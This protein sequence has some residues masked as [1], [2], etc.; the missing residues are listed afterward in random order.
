MEPAERGLY[1]VASLLLITEAA[2]SLSIYEVDIPRHIRRGEDTYLSCLFDLGGQQLYATKW[3]KDGKEIYRYEPSNAVQ[4]KSFP[5]NGITVDL[6]SSN[7]THVRLSAPTLRYSGGYVCEVSLDKP[8]FATEQ[9]KGNVRVV[10]FPSDGPII[11]G[12]NPRYEV[13]DRVTVN[14]TSFRS[15]PAAQLAWYI[16]NERASFTHLKLWPP[17]ID[18][19]DLQTVT[20]GL[21]FRVRP[22]HFRAGDL[23]LKC[24][25]QLEDPLGPLYWRSRELSVAEG[26]PLELSR[27]TEDTSAARDSKCTLCQ[28]LARWI[29]F[30]VGIIL[31]R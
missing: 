29:F 26:R 1:L 19:D 27:R 20:V 5:E 15:Q 18:D 21:S 9:G 7:A 22:R 13:G 25:S 2:C 17:S 4:K 12:G 14:C 6:D 3:Y 8:T 23:K 31:A 30:A 24:V 28:E 11:T 10:V 16:N